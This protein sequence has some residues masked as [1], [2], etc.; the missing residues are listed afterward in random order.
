MKRFFVCTAIF[1]AMFLMVGC[2]DSSDEK[3]LEGEKCEMVE[4]QDVFTC[5]QDDKVVL[6]CVDGKWEKSEECAEGQ[7]CNAQTGKCDGGEN[8]D[9]DNTKPATECGNKVT[10][11]GEVCDGDAK[12]CNTVDPSFISGYATCKTDCSGYD[13][14][15]CQ[16]ADSLKTACAKIADCFFSHTGDESNE[17]LQGEGLDQFNTLYNCWMQCGAINCGQCSAEY[18]ACYGE[19]LTNL[20]CGSIY[21]CIVDCGQD[22]NCQQGCMDKGSPEGQT[23][24]SALM[25]CIQNSCASETTQD[26][27]ISCVNTNCSNELS[28]CGIHF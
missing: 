14:A 26:G 11:D 5:D 8:N 9:D 16:T 22:S 19:P 1:A 24:V 4:G 21:N 10:E 12:E 27:W 15:D 20:D 23:Q 25:Q 3:K 6:K 18:E 13:T 17:C 7:T 28:N 2:G